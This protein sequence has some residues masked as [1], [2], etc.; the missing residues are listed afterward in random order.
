VLS[1]YSLILKNVYRNFSGSNQ[2]EEDKEDYMS[3]IEFKYI[4]E[5]AGLL[6]SNQIK[7]VE[8]NIAFFLAKQTTVDEFTGYDAFQCNYIEFL[9]ALAR[10]ADIISA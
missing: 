10:A 4:F 3:S 7:K 1:F 5:K 6:S 8:L 9:E 2:T